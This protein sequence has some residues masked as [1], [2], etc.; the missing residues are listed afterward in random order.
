[1]LTPAVKWNNVNVLDTSHILTMQTKLIFIKYSGITSYTSYHSTNSTP[2]E[3]RAVCLLGGLTTRSFC[4]TFKW[5]FSISYRN[6]NSYMQ[7]GSKMKPH[8]TS[9]WGLCITLLFVAI[10]GYTPRVLF[11]DS[12][13]QEKQCF[14]CQRNLYIFWIHRYVNTY[15][16]TPPK[17]G[18]PIN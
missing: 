11:S 4:C 14:S 18:R 6:L 12:V 8:S 1:M 10:S 13:V 15:T 3:A 2:C 7:R 5:R 16:H 9:S 17:A